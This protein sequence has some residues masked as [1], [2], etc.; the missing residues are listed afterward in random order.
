MPHDHC[1]PSK[2]GHSWRELRTGELPKGSIAALK[3]APALRVCKRCA[4]LGRVS[5]QGVVHVVE[6]EV[7]A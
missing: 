5:S 4:A 3:I 2:R 7:V 1:P 6:L